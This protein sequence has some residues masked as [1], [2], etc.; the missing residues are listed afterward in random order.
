MRIKNNRDTN[1][2]QLLWIVL[3]VAFSL[4]SCKENKRREEVARIV[5]EWIGKEIKFPENIPCYVLGKDTLPEFCDDNFHKEYKIL[6]YV[7]S[8]G[9]SDCRLNLFE[10]KQVIEETNNLF[11]DKVGFLLFFQ[12]KSVAEMT[13]L[14]L[15]NSFE[16]PVFMDTIGSINRLN[17]FPQAMQHQCYLL[18]EDNKVLA[19]GNP[20]TNIQIWE[21]Y[22]QI[23]SDEKE[24]EPRILTAIEVDKT[25]HDYGN[26]RKGSTNSTDF[27]IH[28]TGTNPLVIYRISVAC[29]CTNVIW[30]KQPISPGQSTTIR[31]EMTPEETGPFRKTVVVYCNANES[32]VKLIVMGETIE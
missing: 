11:P 13:D 20:A 22:K 19:L 21:L 16:Y 17:R 28:N 7:D 27:T 29:G 9:C 1:Q 4:S 31:V 24:T 6:L 12:P 23:I 8:A 18:D 25:I 5:N 32:P 15:R 26:I 10:W 2:K 3:I 14:F 30:D